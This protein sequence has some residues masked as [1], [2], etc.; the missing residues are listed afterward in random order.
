MRAGLDQVLSRCHSRHISRSGVPPTASQE[1]EES[2]PESSGR[3][4]SIAKVGSCGQFSQAGGPLWRTKSLLNRPRR[5]GIACKCSEPT[6]PS[7]PKY[8][9]YLM[10]VQKS[11]FHFH[12]TFSASGRNRPAITS[13]ADPNTSGN[14]SESSVSRSTFHLDSPP[15]IGDLM[16]NTTRLILVSLIAKEHIGHGSTFV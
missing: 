15:I 14:V 9:R 10:T 11:G 8:P 2:L 5:R 13:G 16:E 6:K 12:Q 7:P 4:R 3:S 1:S